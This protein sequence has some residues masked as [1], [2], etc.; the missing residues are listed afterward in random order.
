M[1]RLRFDSSL[2]WPS[3]GWPDVYCKCLSAA[4][5]AKRGFRGDAC[6]LESQTTFVLEVSLAPTVV[7]THRSPPRI[8]PTLSLAVA[9]AV[10]R[11][12]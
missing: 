5:S 6:F 12:T 3:V 1:F 10:S 2:V 9:T 7:R 4:S 11:E 8:S